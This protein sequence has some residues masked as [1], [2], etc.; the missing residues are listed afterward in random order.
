[1][2]KW[3]GLGLLTLAMLWNTGCFEPEEGCLDIRAS[4]YAL[5]ADEPCADDCCTFPQLTLQFLH[6]VVI[7]DTLSNNLKYVDSVYYGRNGV[8]L[9]VNNIQYYLSNVHLF[10][11][12]GQ[13]EAIQDSIELEIILETDR[14]IFKTFENNFALVN[15]GSFRD[16]SIGTFAKSGTYDRMRFA[17]G[18]EGEA[19]KTSPRLC[20]GSASTRRVGH[21]CKP[22]YGIHF[23]KT[24]VVS[25]YHGNG[26]YSP[27]NQHLHRS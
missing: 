1:M 8:P 16:A 23:S 5:D 19:N 25:G 3:I 14:T 2:K 7:N 20:S 11:S 26:Y 21:V 24:G 10:R 6:K 4:N 13:E 22:G 12:S 17:I 18:I 27:G 9:R 15:A